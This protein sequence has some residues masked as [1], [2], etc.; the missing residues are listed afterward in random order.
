LRPEI[1]APS[2]AIVQSCGAQP[3]FASEIATEPSL[4][5][6]AAA[7][8]DRDRRQH[9]AEEGHRR[10]RAAEFLGAQ[11]EF[12]HRHAHTVI[13]GRNDQRGQP[14]IDQFAPGLR[15]PARLAVEHGAHAGL[16]AI[17]RQDAGDRVLQLLLIFIETKIHR[18]AS[19]VERAF[20]PTPSRGRPRTR[21]PIMLR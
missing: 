10:C 14:E 3:S 2:G 20:T 9:M 11:S 16:D 12:D 8:D 21:S 4:L 5:F 13:F 18:P 15:V 7:F 6:V 19:V 1:V 17:G